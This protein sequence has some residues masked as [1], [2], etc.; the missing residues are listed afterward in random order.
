MSRRV[1]LPA[2]ADWYSALEGAWIRGGRTI[3]AKT[4][5]DQ[6]PLFIRSETII[7]MQVGERRDQANNLAD[8]ELHCFLRADVKDSR[9]TIRYACDD[10]ATFAYRRGVRTEIAIAAAVDARRCLHVS[11]EAL[12]DD[13]LPVRLRIVVY[14]AFESVVVTQGSRRRALPLAPHRW[15]FTGRMLRTWISRPF[16]VGETK[17]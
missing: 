16:V 5:A 6:T 4:T 10:G 15:R 12:A 13:Y 1:S 8:I 17:A 7:P 3:T 2:G 14:D 9:T 11:V